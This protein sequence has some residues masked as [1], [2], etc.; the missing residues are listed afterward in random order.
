MDVTRDEFDYSCRMTY[1]QWPSSGF[2]Y[3]SNAEKWACN[4]FEP[5]TYRR[6]GNA[7]FT[8]PHLALSRKGNS[9][10]RQQAA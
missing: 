5:Q 6:A 3:Y 1:R 4:D 8:V 2:D 9:R 10:H 7:F